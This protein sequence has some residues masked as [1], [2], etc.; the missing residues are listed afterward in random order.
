MNRRWQGARAGQI[1][2]VDLVLP[3]GPTCFGSIADQFLP[4]AQLWKLVQANQRLLDLV[5]VALV[6]GASVFIFSVIF[7]EVGTFHLA[8]GT[9]AFTLSPLVV[10][11]WSALQFSTLLPRTRKNRSRT[12]YFFTSVPRVM[13]PATLCSKLMKE[14]W[15]PPTGAR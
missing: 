13:F 14:S 5:T 11:P 7:Q 4:V 10:L 9:D 12:S 3:S 8:F 15:R 1:S 2:N 6:D